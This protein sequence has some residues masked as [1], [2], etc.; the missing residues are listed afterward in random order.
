MKNK[1]PAIKVTYTESSNGIENPQDEAKLVKFFKILLE[2]DRR[3]K[4]DG[5]NN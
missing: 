3:Q 5:K 2:I 1:G 4:Q